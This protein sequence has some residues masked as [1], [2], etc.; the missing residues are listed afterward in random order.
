MLGMIAIAL[1]GIACCYIQ[2]NS[3]DEKAEER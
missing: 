3:L 2:L 1:I